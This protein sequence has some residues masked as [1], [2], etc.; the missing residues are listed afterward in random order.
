MTMKLY[1]SFCPYGTPTTDALFLVEIR[2]TD[3]LLCLDHAN[4]A[5]HVKQSEI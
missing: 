2:G 5:Q 4:R 1:C 3:Y